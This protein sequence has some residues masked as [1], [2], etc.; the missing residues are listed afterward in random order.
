MP[1]KQHEKQELLRL[2]RKCSKTARELL[3]ELGKL[4]VD[5]PNK[6][7]QVIGK[8]VKAIRKKGTIE[9]IQKQLNEYRKVLDTRVLIGLRSVHYEEVIDGSSFWNYGPS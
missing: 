1:G 8:I 7:R 4:K 9:R 3:A 2:A 6:K 5:G